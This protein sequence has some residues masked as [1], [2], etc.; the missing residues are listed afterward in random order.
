[1][2]FHDHTYF[3]VLFV[4]FQCFANASTSDSEEPFQFDKILSHIEA[5]ENERDPKCYATASRLEDFIYGT[6]LENEARFSKNLLQKEWLM[7]IWQ[8]AT[9]SVRETNQD[10]LSK[11]HILS[12]L[13][14]VIRWQLLETGHWQVTL[15]NDRKPQNTQR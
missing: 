11:P 7:H 10:E 12:A 6:P 15:G 2:R 4:T 1:M 3:L 8:T 14:S 5:L 9:E 13:D